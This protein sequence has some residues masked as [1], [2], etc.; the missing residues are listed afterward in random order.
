MTDILADLAYLHGKPQAK[1]KLKALPEH[2][3]VKEE[4]GY[5]F[6]GSGEHLMVKIRKTGENTTFV[7]N[8]LAK[9]CGVKSKDVSWAGH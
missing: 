4:L 8:E 6:T 1:A 9:V 7:A 2:F 5:E 3:V